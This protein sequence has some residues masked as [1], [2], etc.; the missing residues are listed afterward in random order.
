M[1]CAE[2][3]HRKVQA[4]VTYILAIA[5]AKIADP[6]FFILALISTFWLR[7]WWGVLLTGIALGLIY[8][9]VL[10]D[11]RLPVLVAAWIAM[12]CQAAL[13][14]GL[15]RALGQLLYLVKKSVS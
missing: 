15:Y 11:L 13:A 6:M 10:L 14:L 2:I 8:Q 7:K 1:T 9:V 4:T 5:A 12:T 3:D